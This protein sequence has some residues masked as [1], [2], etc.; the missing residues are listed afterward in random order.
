[1]AKLYLEKLNRPQQGVK[2][3]Q[4]IVA[5]AADNEEVAE[6]HRRLGIYYFKAERPLQIR[7]SIDAG[8]TPFAPP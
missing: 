3:Y 1:M 6:A 2:V 7:S 4:D 8:L 5:A